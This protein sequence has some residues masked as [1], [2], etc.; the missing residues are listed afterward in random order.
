MQSDVLLV[1]GGVSMGEFDF[2]EDVLGD[3]GCELSCSTTSP[4]SPASLSW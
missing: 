1:G 3:L 2:V 4:S